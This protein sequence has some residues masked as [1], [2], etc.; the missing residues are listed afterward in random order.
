MMLKFTGIIFLLALILSAVCTVFTQ[1][2][3]ET[4]IELYKKG[5]YK[6]AAKVLKKVVSGNSSDAK[7]W[8]Y[9][10]LSYLRDG[11]E[12]DSIKC[13]E[14]AVALDGKDAEIRTGL[15]FVYLLKNNLPGAINE[16]QAALELTP[17]N[18]D[19][20]YI[21]GIANLRNRGY[22]YAYD[23][24][25]AAIEINPKFAPAY[26]LKSQALVSQFAVKSRPGIWDKEEKGR[27]LNEAVEALEKYLSFSADAE[28]TKFQREYLESLK[29][30]ADYYSR[31]QAP[32]NFDADVLPSDESTIDESSGNE[33]TAGGNTRVKILSKPRPIYTMAAKNANV[34]GTVRLLVGFSADGKVKHVLI[35]RALGFGL[36]KEAVKAARKL[37][38]EPA[39][40]KGKPVSAIKLF[41]YIFTID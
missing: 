11:E 31:N 27:I 33:S 40:E 38:F 22:H 25:K 2:E 23:R 4:G 14:K 24:A 15:A 41:D 21:I 10:G 17:R 18:A 9:L 5:D 20:H 32:A 29:F 35:L 28:E 36:D 16:A 13:L 39:T 3:R 19:A 34:S 8:Y 1:T 12:K 37:K 26:L 6:G 7:V 30:F